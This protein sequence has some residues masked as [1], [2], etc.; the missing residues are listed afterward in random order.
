MRL[1]RRK[2][3]L[4]AFLLVFGSATVA[5]AWLPAVYAGI[6][7]VAGADLAPWAA[8]SLAIHA[9][10]IVGWVA[11]N[12]MPSG[13]N[14]H[15]VETSQISRDAKVTWVDLPSSTVI[16]PPPK[17]EEA[18]IKAK[19]DTATVQT[20]VGADAAA[21][22][23]YPNLYGA[24]YN[25]Q[26][27]QISQDSTVNQ[28]VQVPGYGQKKITSRNAYTYDASNGFPHGAMINSPTS[29]YNNTSATFRYNSE[30]YYGDTGYHNS[31]TFNYVTDNTPPPGTPKTLPQVKTALET[32]PTDNN[33]ISSFKGE[34]D[35][36]IHSNPNVVHFY[37]G[38]TEFQPNAIT[39]SA[40]TQAQAQDAAKKYQAS[41][42][43]NNYATVAA[44]NATTA[45][46]NAA[47]A[48]SAYNAAAAAAAA[49]PGDGAY[50][51][52]AASALAAY[53][54]ALAAAGQAG[55]DAA[56]AAA[57]AA[58]A[59]AEDS[60]S[61]DGDAAPVPEGDAKHEI[62]FTPMDGLKTAL[63][64]TYPFNLPNSI[65]AYFGKFA[66]GAG[67]PPVFDLALPMG[68]VIH[69]D[70]APWDDIATVIRYMLGLV[71]TV[72]LFFYIIH[73]F[74]GIS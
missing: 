10:A 47:S 25:T 55:V 7:Y 51:A 52:A 22:T 24:M 56:G 33:L 42:T 1:F 37:D 48:L 9:S 73:F 2:I 16:P 65:A 66:G 72:G 27:A 29:D 40:L 31:V 59:A 45:N 23:R 17:L 43:I 53:N 63:N 14:T 15:K 70:L 49:H 62:D 46:A 4:I 36:Y 26:F 54:T 57:A 11:Y 35:D 67:T 20:A 74:R 69:V 71:F 8:A 34:I 19:V 50:A 18:T 60:P 13:A 21:K 68:F 5:S 39:S 44:G 28:I 6:V 32:S 12:M 38:A 58:A 64:N 3:V 61:E 41:T 30:V